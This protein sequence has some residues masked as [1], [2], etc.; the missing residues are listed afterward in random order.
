MSK[1]KI[2]DSIMGSGKTSWAIQKMN[3]EG[4]KYIFITPYLTEIERVKEAV[5]SRK[6]YEPSEK[7]GSGS[8]L[9]HLKKLIEQGRNIA[10]T[11]SLFGRIDT[12]TELLL[13]NQGYTLILDEVFQVIEKLNIKKS[14]VDMLLKDYMKVEPNGKVVWI[15]SSYDGRFADI[16]QC[17]NNETLYS[18]GG[19]FFFWTFPSRVFDLFN[20]VYILTYLFDGQIQRAYYDI[21]G[22][23]YE[24]Y[25]AGLNKET[26]TYELIEYN[27]DNEDR[28]SIKKLINIYQG[29]MNTN[30]FVRENKFKT[31]LSSSWLD[32]CEEAFDSQLKKN[33]INYVNN[34]CKAK[35]K[36]IIW[37][38]KKDKSK[39]LKG[40]GYSTRFLP[41][42]IR[43]T[44]DY[45]DS[46]CVMYI[47]NRYMNPIETGFFT[48]HGAEV[49]QDLLAISDLLQF[50]W[51][52]RIREGQP[53]DLYIPSRRMRSLLIKYLNNE[54]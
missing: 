28:E 44:N 16:K 11:H 14:D 8:K 5:T 30:Y 37:T 53:I 38:T 19:S 10:S 49:N 7:L 43:A 6:F 48:L 41:M 24:Y 39:D 20:D 3:E 50:I 13:K 4:G 35:S 40:R 1:V 52:S 54:I 47:Y 9:R 27:R 45:K 18:Y 31:E 2:C 23:E 29:K 34:I 26:N 25:S 22:V 33:M 42:N 17:C 46:R 36:E 15:D 21:F 32:D 12:S 51:R